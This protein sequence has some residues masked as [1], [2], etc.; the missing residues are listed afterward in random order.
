MKNQN[1]MGLFEI[2]V[3]LFFYVLPM[4]CIL[5]ERMINP[6]TDLWAVMIKWFVFFGVGLRLVTCGMKQAISPGFTAKAIFELEDSK[7]YPLI[8]ELGFANICTGLCGI[9][10]LVYINFRITALFIGSIYYGLAFLQ[11]A[12]RK[13]KNNTELF[14]TLT[15]LS[16]VL[17]LLLPFVMNTIKA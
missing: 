17:E 8:R 6:D 12:I 5:F 9:L 1:K 3:I 15:D 16:I 11:H 10:S 4:G 2:F 13:E 7:S 14:V